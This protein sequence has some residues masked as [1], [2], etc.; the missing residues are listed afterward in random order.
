MFFIHNLVSYYLSLIKPLNHTFSHFS[1]DLGGLPSGSGSSVIPYRSWDL[2]LVFPLSM[3][4][5]LPHP[6]GTRSSPSLRNHMFSEWRLACLPWLAF[7]LLRSSSPFPRSSSVLWL[8]RELASAPVVAVFVATV[9]QLWLWA[10]LPS[11]LPLV[12]LSCAVEF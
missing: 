1:E 5:Y 10:L 4:L 7:W 6:S 2:R 11:S 8:S 3:G 9:S 12:G